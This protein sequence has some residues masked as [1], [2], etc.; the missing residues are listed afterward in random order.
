MSNPFEGYD[1]SALSLNALPDELRR[2]KDIRLAMAKEVETVQAAE[3]AIEDRIIREVPKD[4]A[5]VMGLA[6]KVKIM[7]DVV[8]SV[9]DEV[10]GWPALQAF[11]REHDRFDLI[12]KR[13]SS[14]AIKELWE[15]GYN[16]PGVKR[17]TVPKVSL[18]KV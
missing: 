12:Q 13:V 7:S 8:P 6:Y 14:T 4:S 17:M 16:V 1:A 5:G 9:D 10:G 15:A 11:I 3:R 2:I 18:T